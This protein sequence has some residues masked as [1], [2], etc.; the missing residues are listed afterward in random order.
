MLIEAVSR[1]IPG[2]VGL[3]KSVREDS[4]RHGLLDHPHYTRPPEVEGL[5]VPEVLLSGHHEE[6]EGWRAREALRATLEKR[7][8]LLAG[9]ELTEGQRRELVRL[10]G[11]GEG[12]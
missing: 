5:E 2:V 12:D 10:R 1:Q 6:I 11:G 8:E 7:P 3:A 4:F 9:A